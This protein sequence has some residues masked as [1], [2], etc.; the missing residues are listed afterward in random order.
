MKKDT[1]K[2]KYFVYSRKSSEGEDQQVQS[3]DDQLTWAKKVVAERSLM[4]KAFLWEAHSAKLPNGRPVFN[5]MLEKIEKGEA[6]GIVCWQINRLSRNPI[7]AARVQW[8]LQQVK[9]KSIITID[10]E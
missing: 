7:D 2:I 9:I 1:D 8:L 4:V 3:I 5:Q 6:N 10:G